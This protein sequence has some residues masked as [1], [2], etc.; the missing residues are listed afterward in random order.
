MKKAVAIIIFLILALVWR[1]ILH[2]KR[3]YYAIQRIEQLE[4]EIDDIRADSYNDGFNACLEQ[5]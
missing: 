1:E 5:F 4:Y 3:Q 2:A